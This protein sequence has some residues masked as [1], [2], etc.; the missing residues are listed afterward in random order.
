M[1]RK[2]EDLTK[3]TDNLIAWDVVGGAPPEEVWRSYEGRRVL[4]KRLG[5]L[6]HGV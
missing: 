1:E 5:Q 6:Y 3:V 2:Q 4:E